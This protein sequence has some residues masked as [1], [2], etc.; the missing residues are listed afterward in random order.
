MTKQRQRQGGGGGGGSERGERG[1]GETASSEAEALRERGHEQTGAAR[2]Q[3]CSPYCGARHSSP[4]R[5][6]KKGIKAQNNKGN[7]KGEMQGC[8]AD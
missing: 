7:R 8:N 3:V 5:H 6:K 1:E 4:L 2:A